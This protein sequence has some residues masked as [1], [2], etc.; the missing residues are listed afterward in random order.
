MG[1]LNITFDAHGK[2]ANLFT[3]LE[4]LAFFQILG[5]WHAHRLEGVRDAGLRDDC[6]PAKS[7]LADK[8]NHGES[9][10]VVVSLDDGSQLEGQ[11]RKTSL[12]VSDPA[13]TEAV[14]NKDKNI[15]ELMA[16]LKRLA[17]VRS[18]EIA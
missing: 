17:V 10:H 2:Q 4:R 18:I 16:C 12:L 1:L 13:I 6:A 8:T 7:L 11:L 15:A 5:D 3:A 9:L 14:L